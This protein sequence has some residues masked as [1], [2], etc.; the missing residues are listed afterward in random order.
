M[1]LKLKSGAYFG[2]FLEQKEVNG[3]LLIEKAHDTGSNIGLHCHENLYL[4]MVLKGGW[5]ELTNNKLRICKNDNVVIRPAEEPHATRFH[6]NQLNIAFNIEIP[7][8]WLS[9]YS[10]S[11]LPVITQ[12]LEFEYGE[13]PALTKKIYKEFKQYDI[14]ADLAIQGLVLEI[15]VAIARN[16][17]ES[18]MPTWLKRVKE[19]LDD[20]FLQALSLDTLAKVADVHPAYLSRTFHRHFGCTITEYYRSKKIDWA[21]KQL[22]HSE[23]V[24]TDIA[25][26]AGYYDQ[27]HFNKAFRKQIQMTP[28]QYRV[29]FA[30]KSKN[31]T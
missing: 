12:S 21:C 24:I 6:D 8:Q 16:S 11:Q 9:I 1:I 25:L 27:S 28:E 18:K 30:T 7:A 15:C 20:C 3:L 14:F 13:V 17:V 19:H 4:S 31:I 10:N 5:E 2:Q 22:T 29:L 26:E 23:K